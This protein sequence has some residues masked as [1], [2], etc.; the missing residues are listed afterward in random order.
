MYL[1]ESFGSEFETN[2]N[3]CDII[4]QCCK[5]E[6]DEAFLAAGVYETIFQNDSSTFEKRFGKIFGKIK[7][8]KQE[9]G[10][11]EKQEKGEEEK[12]E[13]GEEVKQ[14][15]GEE[16]KQEKGEEEKQEKGEEVK[17]EKGEEEKQE[18]GEEVKQEK[19]EEEKQEK[20]EEEKQE[21]TKKKKDISSKT[22]AEAQ[23]ESKA[24]TS[25]VSSVLPDF[26]NSAKNVQDSNF[27]SASDVFCSQDGKDDKYKV[28][29]VQVN[30]TWSRIWWS[31]VIEKTSEISSKDVIKSITQIAND[32]K[33]PTFSG[34][35]YFMVFCQKSKET[36]NW[37]L[38]DFGDGYTEPENEKGRAKGRG[39]AGYFA[40]EWSDFEGDNPLPDGTKT[41]KKLIGID[42]LKTWGKDV[43]SQLY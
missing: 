24:S 2:Y 14:E 30:Y 42:K 3:L 27:V 41:P 19:G 4:P 21:K 23:A 39:A 6:A 31:S 33:D 20:G 36:N 32:K 25:S 38:V 16:E 28:K 29:V 9:K 22:T 13:K 1:V 10:E 43:L 17:Q 37:K 7:E 11:E 8:E 34:G 35:K 5:N 12:Q 40:A 26:S 15:K 18:K